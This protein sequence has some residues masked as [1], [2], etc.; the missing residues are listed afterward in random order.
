M[1]GVKL[2]SRIVDS[3][4]EKV[5]DTRFPS[6]ELLDRVENAIRTED[7]LSEYAEILVKKLENTRF[8]SKELFNRLER[9]AEQLPVE[10]DEQEE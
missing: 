3:L 4:M 6:S 8:P 5:E 10:Q 7:E 1:D 2:R 9:I